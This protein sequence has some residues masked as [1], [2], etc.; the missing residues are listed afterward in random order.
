MEDPGGFPVLRADEGYRRG[1]LRHT[2]SG[3]HG[4]TQLSVQ[5][6][7]LYRHHGGADVYFEKFPGAQGVRGAF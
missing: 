2:V 6:G 3:F 5:D 4:H 7:A 1:L